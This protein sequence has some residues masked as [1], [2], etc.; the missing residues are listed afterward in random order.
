[1]GSDFASHM[2]K[3]QIPDAKIKPLQYDEDCAIR[4]NLQRDEVIKCKSE[5]KDLN[6]LIFMLPELLSHMVMHHFCRIVLL[7]HPVAHIWF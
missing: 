5:N 6:L 4:L 3:N 7:R 1:M 2:I